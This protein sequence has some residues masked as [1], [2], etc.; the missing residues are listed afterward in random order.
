MQQGE[1]ILRNPGKDEGYWVAVLLLSGGLWT[2]LEER[3]TQDGLV[4]A[5]CALVAVAAVV[6]LTVLR[7]WHIYTVPW[8]VDDEKLTVGSRVV[9]LRDIDSVGMKKGML[10]KD[11]HYLIIKGRQTLRLSALVRGRQREQ[12]IQG[13][14]DV[15]YALKRT[16][17]RLDGTEDDSGSE[18]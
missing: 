7:R 4:A 10:V 17:E 6:R 18:N 14:R 16:I 15:G 13:L 3:L 11:S 8:S 2:V 1:L 9:P 12:S 5:T